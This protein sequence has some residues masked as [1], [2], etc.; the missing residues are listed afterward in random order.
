MLDIPSEAKASEAVEERCESSGPVLGGEVDC[1]DAAVGHRRRPAL[2]TFL[3]SS[4][5]GRVDNVCSGAITQL[6]KQLPVR[7]AQPQA[8]FCPGGSGGLD[9]CVSRRGVFHVNRELEVGT[10]GLIH[11]CKRSDVGTDA[12]TGE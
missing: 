8:V 10:A 6:G 5:A 4:Y 3:H 2:R 7:V 12:F 9:D 11:V 1:V